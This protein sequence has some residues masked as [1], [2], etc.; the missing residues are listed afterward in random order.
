[1]WEQGPRDSWWLAERRDSLSLVPVPGIHL[2][3]AI[4]IRVWR[5]SSVAG[6]E[7]TPEHH[8]SGRDRREIKGLSRVRIEQRKDISRGPLY[9]PPPVNYTT[10]K[11]VVAGSLCVCSGDSCE[12]CALLLLFLLPLLP[13]FYPLCLGESQTNFSYAGQNDKKRESKVTNVRVDNGPRSRFVLNVHLN[14]VFNY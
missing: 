7:G 6:Y 1:M 2:R 11:N 9:P 4:V 5:F 8:V 10:S 13:F 14:G 12:Y 3:P